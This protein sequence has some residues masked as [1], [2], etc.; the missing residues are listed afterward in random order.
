MSRFPVALPET[1]SAQDVFDAIVRH[2]ATM[3][4]RSILSEKQFCAY[5]SRD[6]ASCFVGCFLTDEQAAKG[7]RMTLAGGGGSVADLAASGFL[8]QALMPH[9]G[10]LAHVQPTHDEEPIEEWPNH[11]REIA[12]ERGLSTAVIDEVFPASA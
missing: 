4:G 1:P 10:L 2:A 3:E 6:G 12:S 9:I 5:R 8:P 11:F 7:D